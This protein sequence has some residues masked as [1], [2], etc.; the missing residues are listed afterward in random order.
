MIND[1]IVSNFIK[2][3]QSKLDN[4]HQLPA[5]YDDPFIYEDADAPFSITESPLNPQKE[6]IAYSTEK[7]YKH[8]K[9]QSFQQSHNL[10]ILDKHKL[11]LKEAVLLDDIHVVHWNL[12]MPFHKTIVHF[13]GQL[14]SHPNRSFSL[15]FINDKEWVMHVYDTQNKT[16]LYYFFKS[17]YNLLT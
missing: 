3:V 4:Q 13:K 7:I 2:L 11:C 14:V 15:N 1:R 9:F 16:L 12:H 17:V 8:P 5:L 10:L 6:Y